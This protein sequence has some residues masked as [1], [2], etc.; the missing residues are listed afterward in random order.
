M[1]TAM[2]ATVMISTA[3][4][5]PGKIF[6]LT[7]RIVKHNMVRASLVRLTTA[8]RK[9]KNIPDVWTGHVYQRVGDL[10]LRAD[11]RFVATRL[12]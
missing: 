7:K 9:V 6:L 4:I 8:R 12:R 5:A 3:M 1:A 10:L 2:I 11:H